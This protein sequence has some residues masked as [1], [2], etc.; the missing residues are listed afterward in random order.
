MA[1]YGQIS[2]QIKQ[3]L[4]CAQT[5]HISFR[6]TAVPSLAWAF[7]S[8]PSDR[9]AWVGQTL[10]QTLH[11]CSQAAKRRSAFGVQRPARPPSQR[12]G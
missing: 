2:S 5:R 7:S 1:S 10:P 4:S 8:R 9:I 11:S 12:L 6:S 3:S